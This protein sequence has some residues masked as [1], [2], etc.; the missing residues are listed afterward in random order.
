MKDRILKASCCRGFLWHRHTIHQTAL[1]PRR[2]STT[3]TALSFS[4]PRCCN[5]MQHHKK[6]RGNGLAFVGDAKPLLPFCLRGPI[7][8]YRPSER[9]PETRRSLPGVFLS[10]SLAISFCFV[11]LV[12]VFFDSFFQSRLQHCGYLQCSYVS[13]T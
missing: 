8:N 10:F 5:V 3:V 9:L 1:C 6:I 12:V 4:V 7:F 11:L 2:P 13:E